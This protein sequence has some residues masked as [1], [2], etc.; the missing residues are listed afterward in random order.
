VNEETKCEVRLGKFA[1]CSCYQVKGMPKV[2][3]FWHMDLIAEYEFVPDDEVDK[4]LW[5][6]REAALA[7]LS[8]PTE[9]EL[10]MSR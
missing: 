8:Y 5:L 4:L 6:T 2:V 10:V 1:G 9:R 3:L 7:K